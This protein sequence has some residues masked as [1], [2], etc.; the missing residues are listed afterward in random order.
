MILYHAIHAIK[1]CSSIS[2]ITITRNN[3]QQHGDLYSGGAQLEP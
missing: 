1:T 3:K 2:C